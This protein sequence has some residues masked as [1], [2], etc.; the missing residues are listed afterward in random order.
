M[1]GARRR[2]LLQALC[3]RMAEP[4]AALR[5]AHSWDTLAHATLDLIEDLEPGRGWA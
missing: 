3:T 4:I 5:A 1:S 2:A